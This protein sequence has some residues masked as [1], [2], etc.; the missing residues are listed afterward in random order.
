M[1]TEHV[2]EYRL[3]G[4]VIPGCTSILQRAGLSDLSMVPEHVLKAKSRLGS[5]IHEYTHFYDE[6]DFDIRDL[7]SFPQYQNRVRGWAQFRKD[8]QFE[9]S[10]IEQA[11]AIRVNGMVFGVKPDRFG[12]GNFGPGGARIMTT[13]EIKCTAEIEPAHEIQTAGQALALKED[14]P[15]PGRVICQ[16]LEEADAAKKFYRVHKCEDRHDEAV[17]MWALGLETYKRNKG[18]IR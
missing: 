2:H 13:V 3:A 7:D 12:F 17:F 5:I 8:W 15:I 9:P 11:M 18:I 10:V 6:D 4:R 14:C 1:E 16:L